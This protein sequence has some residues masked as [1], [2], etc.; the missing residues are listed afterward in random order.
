MLSLWIRKKL[1]KKSH[2]IILMQGKP[3]NFNKRERST[4]CIYYTIGID[5]GV[6]SSVKIC[7]QNATSFDP[8]DRLAKLE[9]R[10]LIVG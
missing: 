10:L 4:L 9:I 2:L 3:W 5:L 1:C 6:F 7:R 8:N